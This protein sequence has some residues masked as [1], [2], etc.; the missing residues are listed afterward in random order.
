MLCEYGSI[1]GII[2]KA[3]VTYEDHTRAQQYGDNYYSLGD[4]DGTRWNF[5]SKAP[6]AIIAGLFRPYLWEA[7][8]PVML[9]AGIENLGFLIL[10]LVIL[11]RTGPIKTIRFTL[12]EPL[13]IFSLSFAI[14]FAFAVG[15]ATANFG[16]L[17]RLKIPLIPFLA[18]GLFTLYYRSMELRQEKE[19]D[20]KKSFALTKS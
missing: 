5:F 18:V 16:A 14:A 11:W 15:I 3:I 9:L 19:S 7:R 20:Y 6:K 1:D 4:F 13:I 17:V 8:N 2:H 10:V 12:E